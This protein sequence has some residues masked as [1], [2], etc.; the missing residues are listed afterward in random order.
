[1]ISEPEINKEWLIALPEMG[2]STA[3]L[4]ILAQAPAGIRER[5]QWMKSTVPYGFLKPNQ[6]AHLLSSSTSSALTCSGWCG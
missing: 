1:K 4:C 5:V 2:F 3:S 6:P